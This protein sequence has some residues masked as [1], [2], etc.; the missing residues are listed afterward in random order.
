MTN[1]I[2]EYLIFGKGINCKINIIQNTLFVE[3]NPTNSLLTMLKVRLDFKQHN[4]I[5]L[6]YLKSF[7]SIKKEFYQYICDRTDQFDAIQI[8]GYGFAG[9]IAQ[10]ASLGIYKNFLIPSSV[11]TYDSPTPFSIDKRE[12]F[13]IA[14]S[15]QEHFVFG[16]DINLQFYTKIFGYAFPSNIQEYKII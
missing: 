8:V 11:T 4:G 7:Q 12:D 3:F 9:A 13:D 15:K 6:G 5:H 10:I 16:Y 14:A 2:N 1:T